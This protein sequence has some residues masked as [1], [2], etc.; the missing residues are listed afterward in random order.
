MGRDVLEIATKGLHMQLDLIA[1]ETC[2][3]AFYGLSCGQYETLLAEARYRCQVCGLADY[4]NPT[5]KL[6]IDHDASRGDWAVRGLLCNT[7]NSTLGIDGEV[8]RDGR[9]AAYLANAWYVREL[10]KLGLTPEC[11]PEPPPGVYVYATGPGGGHWSRRKR[12]AR[13]I[14]TRGDRTWVVSHKNSRPKTW[15]ELVRK[16]GPHRLAVMS[17]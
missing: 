9:Y 17:Q 4:V 12:D 10:A 16:Y 13:R 6:F 5:G 2:R 15:R 1:H 3:H 11:P 14:P 7:C 8:P